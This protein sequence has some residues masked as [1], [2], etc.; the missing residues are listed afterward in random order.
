[1]RWRE[2]DPT[3]P[4]ALADLHGA[5][6][7]RSDRWRSVFDRFEARWSNNFVS[8][9]GRSQQDLLRSLDLGWSE[10]FRALLDATR[11]WAA[12]VNRA[13]YLGPA[14][15]IWMG[16]V[17]IAV[18]IAA[19]AVWTRWRRAARLRQTLRIEGLHGAAPGRFMRQL[20][21]YLDMLQVL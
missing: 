11:E 8:F 20:G 10:R 15:Y 14:G 13:F 9:D 21:F 17:A 18:I 2:L 16:I 12:R 1:H 7:T 3:P 6:P 4:Q 19:I 5:P